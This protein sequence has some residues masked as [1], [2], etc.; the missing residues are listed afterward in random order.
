MQGN[1]AVTPTKCPGIPCSVPDSWKP[2]YLEPA[3]RPKATIGC[4]I[5]LWE[6]C[7]CNMFRTGSNVQLNHSWS[8]EEGISWTR[9]PHHGSFRWVEPKPTFKPLHSYLLGR[10]HSNFPFWDIYRLDILYFC[11]WKSLVQLKTEI[12]LV[13][14]VLLPTI[15][16]THSWKSV[17]DPDC[18]ALMMAS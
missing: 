4:N 13:F 5:Y 9:A 2:W 8:L 10:T 7:N 3:V 11:L 14:F 1:V 16:H 17:G 18:T 6:K 15:Q 12:G